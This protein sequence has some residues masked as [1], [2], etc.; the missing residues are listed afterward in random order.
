MLRVVVK[1]ALQRL[2]SGGSILTRQLN[3][4]QMEINSGGICSQS[5]GQVEIRLGVGKAF[6]FLVK[7]ATIVRLP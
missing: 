1:R 6:G 4:G 5:Q 2:P 3:R 7:Q